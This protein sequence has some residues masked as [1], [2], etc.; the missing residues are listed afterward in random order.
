MPLGQW[1]SVG[2]SRLEQKSTIRGGAWK[3][4]LAL[5]LLVFL[6]PQTAGQAIYAAS[7]SD[8]ASTGGTMDEAMVAYRKGD[9]AEAYRLWLPRAQAGEPEA[10]Y[11]I[12][13]LF[14]NGEGVDKDLDQALIWYRRAADGG[15]P[16][17][18]YAMGVHLERGD[19]IA[20]DFKAA[21]S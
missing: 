10:Q 17:A 6:L 16:D 20:Q 8:G 13:V 12:G 21:E 14:D 1:E 5:V 7:E 18:Q 15:Y 2:L 9:F 11:R 19:G 3:L 4:A